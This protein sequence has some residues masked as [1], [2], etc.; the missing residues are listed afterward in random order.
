MIAAN[1]PGRTDNEIKNVWN[2][3][4]KKQI[5]PFY[6]LQR[7]SKK[8]KKNKSVALHMVSG[9]SVPTATEQQQQQ[10]QQSQTS[11]RG[12]VDTK[13][14]S[15]SSKIDDENFWLEALSIVYSS[16]SSSS[17]S[18]DLTEA[19]IANPAI[20]QQCF[21]LYSSYGTDDDGMEFLVNFSM[22]AVDL[23]EL[24]SF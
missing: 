18:M 2:T 19:E 3:Y 12:S 21:D 22:G 7:E 5:D 10:Q 14:E 9:M 1:L 23:E 17:S 13:E 6:T 16:A 11:D 20:G 24:S 8:K 15:F 4:L